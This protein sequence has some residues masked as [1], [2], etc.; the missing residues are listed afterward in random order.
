[1]NRLHAVTKP[2]LESAIGDA[3]KDLAARA[4]VDTIIS[5]WGK[6]KLRHLLQKELKEVIMG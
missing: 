4:A 5:T 1:M 3:F 2:L 6:A